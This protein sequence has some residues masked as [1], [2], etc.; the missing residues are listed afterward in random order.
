MVTLSSSQ[1][2]ID[3]NSRCLIHCSEGWHFVSGNCLECPAGFFCPGGR[4]SPRWCPEGTYNPLTAQVYVT[5]CQQ[6]PGGQEPNPS[7]TSC[8]PCFPDFSSAEGTSACQ[9]C[10]AGRP[11][12]WDHPQSPEGITVPM[13]EPFSHSCVHQAHGSMLQ[14]RQSAKSAVEVLAVQKVQLR[15]ITPRFSTTLLGACNTSSALQQPYE[16]KFFNMSSLSTSLSVGDLFLP[17]HFRAQGLTATPCPAGSYESREHFARPGNGSSSYFPGIKQCL[18]CPAGYFCPNGTSYP[19]PCPAGT[20]NPLQGQDESTDCRLCPAG[21]ACTQMGLVTPDSECTAGYVC[22]VGSSSPHAP[23]SACPPGSFSNHSD[24]FDK[25]QCEICPARFACTRDEGSGGKQKPPVPCP[26]GHYCPPG[27]KHP[28]QYRCA[29]GTWSNGTGLAAEQECMLCPA[30]RFCV[31]GAQA[32][33]GSCSAGHFCPEGTQ[34]ST[35]FPC[36]EG[37]YSTRLGNDEIEDCIACP[38]GAYCPQGTAKPALCP[39]GTYFSEQGAKSARDCIP[40]PGGYHCPEMGTI[41]PYP[42]GAGKFSDPGA[43]SC[44][45]CLV[46]HF[47][48]DT[49]TSR[50]AMLLRMVCPAGMLCPEGLAAAPSVGGNACPR[51]YYC[52]QGDI[53]L[54][55]SFHLQH[56]HARPCPNGTYGGQRGLGRADQCLLCPL[57]KYCYRDGHEPQG[58]SQPTG[59]CPPGYACPPGTGFP[60][61][62]PCLPG[63]YWDNSTMEE[64]DTCKSCPAG[65][66][67]DSVAMTQPKVCPLGSYC[68][69]GRSQPKSCP[70]G[71]YGNRKGLARQQDCS[72]CRAGFYCAAHGQTTPSGRCES[73]FYCRSRAVSPLPTDGVTGNVCPPGSYCPPGS[74]V[75]ILCP[76]GTYSNASG[77]R[78]QNQCLDCP[79]GL[80]CDGT[81]THV[82]T[83]PCKPGYFCPGAARTATQM[84]AKEGYYT[85]EG[86]VQPELCPP[87]SFQ[88]YTAQSACIDCP[89]GMFCNHTGL[90]EPLACPKGHYCPAKSVLPLLCP[91]GTYLDIPGGTR[92]GTCKPCPAGKYCS[93]PGLVWPEGSCQPGYYCLQG[94]GS[95]SPTGPPFGGPCPAGHY[96]PAGTKQ[97]REMPCPAGTWNEQ[98][99]AQDSSWCLPCPPGFFCSSP[100]RVSPTGPC[101]PGFFCRGGTRTARPVDRVTGDV[102]PDGHSC[103]AGSAVPSPCPDGEYSAITGQEECF[104]CPAALYCKNGVRYLCPPGFYCPPKTGVSLRPCP[105]GTYNP[106]PGIDRVERCLK[107]PADDGRGEKEEQEMPLATSGSS[108]EKEG[109][110]CGEWGLS[111]PTGPCFPGYFCSSGSSVPNPDGATNMDAGSPCPPGHFCPA[112]TKAP[113]PCPA[114]TFSDREGVQQ[115][116][117]MT[118]GSPGDC[119]SSGC[120]CLSRPAASPARQAITASLLGLQPL[121]DSALR[122][123]TAYLEPLHLHLQEFQN[124]EV[125]ALRATFVQRGPANHFPVYQ[126]LT[127]ISLCKLLASLAQP[128]TT[129]LQIPPTTAI[130]PAHLAFTALKV[131]HLHK[132]KK[133]H[134]NS[135]SVESLRHHISVLLC[136]G[137]TRSA[138]AFPCP[139]GYYNPDPMTQSLDSCLPCPPGY[140]C[141]KEN[142]TTVSGKCDAGWFCI[143]AAWTPQPFDLDNYT[144]G[145]CLCPATATGG[146]CFPGS[147]CPEGSPEPIPCPPGFYCNAPGLSAPSGECAA[148]FYCTGGAFSPKPV[149]GVTGKIC[150]EGMYCCEYFSASLILDQGSSGSQVPSLC[151]P[152]TFSNLLGQSRIS[153][154][155]LCPSGFYCEGSGLRTPSGECRE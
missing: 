147:F 149:D 81:N 131:Y 15:W 33:S 1:E 100:G 91:V 36:P 49:D 28:M 99:G 122:A 84:M 93:K 16:Q 55:L 38:T 85:L 139:R 4:M 137:G 6:C 39:L 25:S 143:S 155:Q 12:L 114:G 47:C 109:M 69:P 13:L 80:Y 3:C 26:A 27:T 70:E 9:L 150:P 111:A 34:T 71:T 42:C 41:T 56:S 97:P 75:P 117:P 140:Y 103:P 40:C 7:H 37:T 112:G 144:N 76:P 110:F 102:C 61:S 18:K 17:S 113:L 89:E 119:A 68:P 63:S 11:I 120:I 135:A 142:L 53:E 127:T 45:P 59:D 87:G 50:E 78:K 152:G 64:G 104:P 60:F 132:P 134:T 29:P 5:S 118:L 79:P 10:P 23:S 121:P 94:S 107:C 128:V 126:E 24:L 92:I 21:R 145:N 44:S 66:F 98:K 146:K 43:T 58:I 138:T 57:G 101:A 83:G 30:G 74:P 116:L 51:G 72:P 130:S 96:C 22:P 129:A 124:R 54:I 8:V 14:D 65:F 148:G 46:G 2:G 86:A 136:L 31:A 62:F 108:T 35:Q 32:P 90:V 95:N 82:P 125:L 115:R 105:P 151:P 73:G 20:Y 48:A 141:G 19:N 123:S 52:P 133:H 106:S 67:C 153:D 88:P 154:C 77:L